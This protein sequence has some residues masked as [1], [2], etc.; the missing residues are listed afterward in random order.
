MATVKAFV[1]DGYGTLFVLAE[2]LKRLGRSAGRFAGQNYQNGAGTQQQV[3]TAYRPA[4]PMENDE[5]SDFEPLRTPKN[6]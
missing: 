6:E 2:P 1:F 5:D 3:T 4:Q